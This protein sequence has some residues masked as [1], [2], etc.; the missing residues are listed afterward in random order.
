MI[1]SQSRTLRCSDSNCCSA[2]V[3]FAI[4]A[5]EA[6]R[7]RERAIN[8]LAKTAHASCR[9]LFAAAEHF[10]RRANQISASYFLPLIEF[11]RYDTCESLPLT[12]SSVEAAHDVMQEDVARSSI[13]RAKQ[14]TDETIGDQRCLEHLGFEPL[15]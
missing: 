14:R 11:D 10:R 5:L 9:T 8:G 7:E 15:I 12:R 4:L 2:D 1:A 6:A 3:S 13:V